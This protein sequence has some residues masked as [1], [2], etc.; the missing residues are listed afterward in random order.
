MKFG[1]ITLVSL[2]LLIG[3]SSTIP[4]V[5]EQT[6]PSVTMSPRQALP[7]I[8]ISD[9][10]GKS[11]SEVAKILGSPTSTETVKPSGTPCPCPKQS[12]R[13]GK[14]EIVFIAGKADW[15]TINGLNNAPYSSET[16]TLFGIEQKP[17]SFSND[18]VMRWE[19][20]PGLSEVSIFPAQG[21]VDYV[22][23]KTATP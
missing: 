13:D 22:Y 14:I 11:P 16:L 17:A 3:C 2:I 5:V 6:S 21:G 23:I 10:A 20:I 7:T 4:E 15:I 18:S 12:Y 8:K 9:I 19:N 1:F